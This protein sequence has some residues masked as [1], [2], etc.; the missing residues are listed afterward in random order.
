MLQRLQKC[1]WYSNRITC[2]S[3]LS[4]Y[5]MSMYSRSAINLRHGLFLSLH[6]LLNIG[7][8]LVVAMGSGD[9]LITRYLAVSTSDN[10]WLHGEYMRVSGLWEHDIRIMLHLIALQ[11]RSHVLPHS[12][13]ADR[14]GCSHALS[15]SESMRWYTRKTS[16]N[17]QTCISTIQ[18]GWLLWSIHQY[19][20]HSILYILY[21]WC[22]PLQNWTSNATKVQ[23]T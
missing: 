16:W 14:S 23:F 19:T 15:V 3:N 17:S 1:I 11:R 4:S 13:S 6:Y 18:G 22:C 10:T 9:R 7:L 21:E 2:H 8:S 5:A 20:V 12:F